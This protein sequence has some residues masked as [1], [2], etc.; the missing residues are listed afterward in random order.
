VRV[1]YN[2]YWEDRLQRNYT[3]VMPRHREI[4]RIIKERKRA[5]KILDLGCGEGHILQM[6]PDFYE[7]YGSDVSDVA[8]SLIKDE[9]IHKKACDL[10][11]DF[12]FDLNFDVIIASEVLEHLGNPYNVLEKVKEHLAKDGLFL[13]TTPSV[14]LWKHRLQ[15][16]RGRFPKYDPS[17]INFWDID[18]F[19]ELLRNYGYKILDYYPTYFVLPVRFTEAMIAKLRPLHKLFGEQFLFICE[20]NK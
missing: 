1:D 7:K 17:H 6:L 18:S 2:Q 8:L 10:N 3:P 15:L 12:P 16:L 20:V 13:V 11:Q 19:A 5:G 4:V 9:K 14:T